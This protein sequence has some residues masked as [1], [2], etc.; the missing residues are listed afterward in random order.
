MFANFD[1]GGACGARELAEDAEDDY[2]DEED[3]VPL[4]QRAEGVEADGGPSVLRPVSSGGAKSNVKGQALLSGIEIF[5][6]NSIR[7]NIRHKILHKIQNASSQCTCLT[8][9]AL[10]CWKLAVISRKTGSGVWKLR[11]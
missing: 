1:Q 7:Y 10:S 4:P 9:N 6:T 11:S 5:K 2:D 8:H 3:R